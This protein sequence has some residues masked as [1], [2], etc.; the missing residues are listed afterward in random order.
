VSAAEDCCTLREQRRNAR[1]IPLC[2]RRPLEVSSGLKATPVSS[3]FDGLDDVVVTCRCGSMEA[4]IQVGNRGKILS[5]TET[6][7]NIAPQD[8]TNKLVIIRRASGTRIE[9]N[10]ALHIPLPCINTE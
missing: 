6:Q 4:Q 8:K 1:K 3:R 5:R 7:G 2:K 10:L 9:L